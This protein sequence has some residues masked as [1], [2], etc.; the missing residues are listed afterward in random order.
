VAASSR[1][2]C[3][4]TES[5]QP[6]WFSF[7]FLSVNHPG[8]AKQRMLRDIFLI[9]QPP[10]LAVMQGGDYALNLSFSAAC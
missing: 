9:A 3:A 7:C 10:L 4:A 2:F 1:K 6:G 5:T 8:F